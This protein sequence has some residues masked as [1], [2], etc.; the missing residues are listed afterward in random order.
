MALKIN[1]GA[2]GSCPTH[3]NLR[4]ASDVQERP[5]L[6]VPYRAGVVYPKGSIV[7]TPYFFYTNTAREKGNPSMGEGTWRVMD[8]AEVAIKLQRLGDCGADFI[9]PPILA[10]QAADV[11]DEAIRPQLWKAGTVGTYKGKLYTPAEGKEAVTSLPDTVPEDWAGGVT[12]AELVSKLLIS[13]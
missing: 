7:Y 6:F 11:C 1:T 12:P 3:S 4:V 8:M 9:F 2:G 10:P 5:V 13:L